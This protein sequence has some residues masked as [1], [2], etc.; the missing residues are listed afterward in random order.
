MANWKNTFGWVTFLLFII[1]LIFFGNDVYKNQRC[2]KLNIK[3][4]RQNE[5]DFVTKENV[6]NLLTENGN[7]P[8]LGSKFNLLNFRNL[9]KQVLHNKLIESC[10]ISRTL[11]GELVVKIEQRNPIARL[12]TTNENFGQFKGLYL[13][14]KGNL[15]PLSNNFTKR[16]VLVSGNYLIGKRHFKSKKDKNILLFLKKIEEEQFWKANI[17]HLIIDSDQ[18]ISFLPLIG[19]FTFEY[20][21][22]QEEEFDQ[23]MKKIKIFYQEI[24]P[25]NSEKYKKVSV[26][27]KNQIVC[28][29]NQPPTI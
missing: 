17:T 11:G 5:G 12:V 29:V 2:K 28:Q 23:K 21:I 19:N 8:I 13:D 7:K 10:Q 9:E 3:L 25:E 22:P 27:Y 20:G 16:V 4:E 26:K 18:N 14:E 15:F 6:L 24:E 1:F